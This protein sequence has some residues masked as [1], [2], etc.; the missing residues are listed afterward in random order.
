MWIV[1]SH[2]KHFGNAVPESA[3][4]RPVQ[5]TRCAPADKLVRYIE[6]CNYAVET[7]LNARRI[8]MHGT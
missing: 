3:P 5:D 4:V 2:P 8:Q 1:I 6:R 7:Y